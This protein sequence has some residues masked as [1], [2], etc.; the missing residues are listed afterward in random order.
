MAACWR[1]LS[2][3]PGIDLH[4]IAY[5][6]SQAAPSSFDG[7]VM[8][9]VPAAYLT[10]DRFDAELR[11]AVV[12]CS[13]DI[14][15]VGGWA[16]P[17]QRRLT[18]DPALASAKFVMAMDTPFRGTLRQRMGRY[19]FGSY[20]RRIDRVMVAGERTWR[21]AL[22]LG[23]SEHQVHRGLYGI[24]HQRFA[25]LHAQRLA[26][27]WPRR[28]VYM[29]RYHRDKAIDVLV[30]AHAEYAAR[31]QDPWELWCCGKGPQAHLLQGH[32]RIID[33]GFVQ[34]E[35][36]PERFLQ[37]GCFVLPS[38]YE[39]WGAAMVEAGAAGLPIIAS[40]ACG[41]GVDMLHHLFNGFRFTTNDVRRLA[42]AMR[43]IHD[44][45]PDQ[46]AT[47]GERSRY[48]AS[49]YGTSVW[50]DRFLELVAE[51]RAGS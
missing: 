7:S 43:W 5:P 45:T 8:S 24:D 33:L 14:V 41:A 35:H 44:R 39:P 31:V 30:N 17:A 3:R 19:Y 51:L 22:Q 34:P 13:P 36:Q 40:E 46:L 26:A 49:A 10:Q 4:V 42:S 11:D 32:D 1:E 47:M 38:R 37:A 9:G 48:L 29:G 2:H 28:F 50:A 20:F 18:R 23:F 12:R 21:L 27:G 6:P 15:V 16:H 25:P